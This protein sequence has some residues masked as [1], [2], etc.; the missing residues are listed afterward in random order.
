M[1]DNSQIVFPILEQITQI[2]CG[3]K[4]NFKTTHANVECVAMEI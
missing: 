2:G 3:K 4:A 1:K